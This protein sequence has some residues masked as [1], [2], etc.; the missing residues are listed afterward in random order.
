MKSEA[1]PVT[2][3]PPGS[4]NRSRNNANS[5]KPY[6]KFMTFRVLRFLS[7]MTGL[8]MFHM[9]CFGREKVD[10]DQGM[11]ICA[12]HQSFLD[13]VLVGL[14]LEQP[15]NYLARRSLFDSLLLGPIIRY[16]DAIPINRDGM[17]L[18]GL[19]ESMKRLR[20]GEKVLMFPEGTRTKD[21][22]IQQIRP[23]FCAV[24]RRVRVPLLPVGFDGAFDAW[25][26]NSLLPRS[27]P[28]HIVIG[29]PLDPSEMVEL[30]DDELIAELQ[31]R[32]EVCFQK[33][34]AGRDRAM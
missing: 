9:R 21:G 24:A 20:R 4:G 3:N 33:A 19:K 31:S 25:P 15:I 7:R 2:D 1:T 8:T 34:R 10:E 5:Q 11:L 16:L 12:N 17:G 13:P 29:D 26:R 27:S 14:A 22:D 6:H 18:E 28:I 30:S 32:L 23:G